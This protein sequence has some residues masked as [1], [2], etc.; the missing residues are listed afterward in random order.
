MTCGS[1]RSCRP[2][3]EALSQLVGHL[4][5]ALNNGV[6]P[7]EASGVLAHLAV[8]CG[9]PSAVM[10]LDVYEQVYT[11]RKVDVATLSAVRPP[12]P[13]P[14]SDAARTQSVNE[15]F[16]AIS[17][18]FAQLTNDVVFGDLWRRSDLSVR[19][20]SPVTISA[21]AA[22]GDDDQLDVYLRRAVESGLTRDQI[23]EA[24]IHL[25]FYAGWPKA[26]RGMTAVTRTLGQ[27]PAPTAPTQK[28]AAAVAEPS[29]NFTGSVAVTQPFNGTGGARIG[30]A[31]VTFQPGART[32]WHSHPLG[33]LLA[34]PRVAAGHSW[35]GS[36]ARHRLRRR[37]VD[38]AGREALARS[39]ALHHDDACRRLRARGRQRGQ[40]ARTCDRRTVP[41]VRSRKSFRL[42][43][44]T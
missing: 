27:T 37:R 41:K 33:Q 35:K 3:T 19:D 42:Y 34:S 15:Q 25:G 40:L 9:W 1:G 29:G 4:G 12:L 21:L 39:D 28:P 11:A 24:L 8:Y 36:H 23:G 10:A 7:I 13:A 26:T 32:R 38:A 14:A 18:K 6:Q 22:M 16:A 31:T 2:A 20:R 30:G 43:E 17:P 44:L 5:R